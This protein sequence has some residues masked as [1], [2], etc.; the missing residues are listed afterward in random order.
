MSTA[1]ATG[2]RAGVI[3]P[4]FSFMAIG[5]SITAGFST[6][7][8]GFRSKINA[9]AVRSVVWQGR[10]VDTGLHEGYN[11]QR[12]DQV[13]PTVQPIIRI[14]QPRTLLITLGVNDINQGQSVSSTLSEVIAAAQT[15]V[16]E[17]SYVK[18]AFIS[19]IPIGS[20]MNTAGASAFNSGL[21]AA[22]AALSDARFVAASTCS[23]LVIATDFTDGLHPNEVGYQKMADD[24]LVVLR[25][26]FPTL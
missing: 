9:G 1:R 25:T 18:H 4:A 12:C 24:W 2:G 3:D 15:L 5:D 14:M 19:E 26:V 6:N 11:G 8:G 13:L 7:L 23:R 17:S 22:V 16:A 20:T 21:A 10:N